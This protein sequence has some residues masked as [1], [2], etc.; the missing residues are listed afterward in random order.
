M[1]PLQGG[2]PLN[3]ITMKK[4]FTFNELSNRYPHTDYYVCTT[5]EDSI[6]SGV[7]TPVVTVKQIIKGEE[8]KFG[9]KVYKDFKRFVA[10]KKE[11]GILYYKEVQ[12]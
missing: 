12:L 11:E 1:G 6:S 4:L 8:T 7:T 2:V 3:S 10:A 5:E 9:G